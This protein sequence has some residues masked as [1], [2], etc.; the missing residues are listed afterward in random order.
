[1]WNM[2]KVLSFINFS[3][4][5][6]FPFSLKAIQLSKEAM[7]LESTF[8]LPECSETMCVAHLRDT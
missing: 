2:Q 5:F 4:F 1:M 3:F 7:A 8:F 6:F